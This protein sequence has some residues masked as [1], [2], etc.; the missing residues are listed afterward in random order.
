MQGH[1]R[2]QDGDERRVLAAVLEHVDDQ[3]L[4]GLAAEQ[5]GDP[6]QPAEAGE[7]EQCRDPKEAEGRDGPEQVEPAARV[8]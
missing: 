2:Q 4:A 6:G 3:V 7:S 1:P 5:P 8:R